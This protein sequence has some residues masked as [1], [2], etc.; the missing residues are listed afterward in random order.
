VL[1][2][3][4]EGRLI[5]LYYGE[6]PP[7]DAAH[8]EACDA[9]RTAY[10]DLRRDLDAVV[11]EDAPARPPDFEEEL[12]ARLAPRLR[13][14]PGTALP[15]RSRAWTL[16]ALAASLAVAFVVGR[17]TAPTLCVPSPPTAGDPGVRERILVVAVGDHLERAEMFLVELANADP[18]GPI[19]ET[20]S[21]QTLLASTRLI[22]QSAG[23][24]G[25]AAATDVLEELER[26]LVDVAHA[27]AS[28]DQAELAAARQRV[29][30]RGLLFKVRVLGARTRQS[31]P[32]PDVTL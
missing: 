27:A 8:V 10:Q 25:D 1:S 13:R 16:T 20:D 9:C 28:G 7:E 23:R 11:A 22:R 19:V 24:A 3:L 15:R 31:I 32:K 29:E 14:A 5:L 4:D 18:G 21:A 2:H 12:W 6:A 30:K 17:A 26:V